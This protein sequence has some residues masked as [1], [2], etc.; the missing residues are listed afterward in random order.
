M[1]F[2]TGRTRAARDIL[3]RQSANTGN[4]LST[5]AMCDIAHRLRDVLTVGRDST[6]SAACCMKSGD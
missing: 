6:S 4:H 5:I 2:Y 1:V 3:A